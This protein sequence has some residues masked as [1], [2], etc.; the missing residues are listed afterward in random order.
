MRAQYRL[1]ES[2]PNQHLQLETVSLCQLWPIFIL[3]VSGP[4]AA[5]LAGQGSDIDIVVRS[6]VTLLH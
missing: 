5:V 6:R 1:L 4:T 2:C 3:L